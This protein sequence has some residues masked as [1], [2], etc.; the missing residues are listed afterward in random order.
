MKRTLKILIVGAGDVARRLTAPDS[1]V[2]LADRAQWFGLARSAATA[3]EL[4]RVGILPIMG[5]LDRRASLKRAGAMARAA[6]FAGIPGGGGAPA[7]IAAQSGCSRISKIVRSFWPQ[8]WAALAASSCN[9]CFLP[10]TFSAGMIA[11]SA[12]TLVSGIKCFQNL[13]TRRNNGVAIAQGRGP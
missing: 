9:A 3:D 12:T 11:S 2:S 13:E 5:D 7:G 1:P 8:S 4:R 10:L 6:T